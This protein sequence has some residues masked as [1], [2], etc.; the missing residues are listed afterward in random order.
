MLYVYFLFISSNLSKINF[1][2]TLQGIVLSVYLEQSWLCS[3]WIALSV[4]WTLSVQSV[5]IKSFQILKWNIWSTVLYNVIPILN[6]I[7]VPNVWINSAFI[8]LI[9]HV[10]VITF[11]LVLFVLF[12]VFFIMWLSFLNEVSVYDTGNPQTSHH[13]VMYITFGQYMKCSVMV[14]YGFFGTLKVI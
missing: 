14:N 9:G 7:T 6:S 1:E 11:K 3:I 12:C 10:D 8:R 4:T 13:S 2:V 5:Y